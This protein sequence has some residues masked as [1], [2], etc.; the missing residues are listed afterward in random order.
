MRV[1]GYLTASTLDLNANRAKSEL[2]CFASKL[3]KP[4]C[5]WFVENESGGILYRPELMR[6]LD[7]V[8]DGDVLLIEH[9]DRIGWLKAKNWEVLKATIVGKG[10]RVVSKDLPTTHQLIQLSDEFAERMLAAINDMMFDMLAAIARKDF[11]D[12][13]IRQT[14]GV[15]K[16]KEAGKYRGRPINT[17][18]H[19]DIQGLLLDGKSYTY[20]KNLLGCSDHT[21]SKVK[22]SKMNTDEQKQ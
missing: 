16:A 11:D 13:R 8:E 3:G 6:L 17:K 12:R 10:I 22:K 5:A 20:I 2:E 9:V 21:I 7:I 1:Y 4:V 19:N 14:Q 18:L 15:M